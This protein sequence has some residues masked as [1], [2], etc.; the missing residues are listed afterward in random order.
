MY[1]S[2]TQSPNG[3]ASDPT[4]AIRTR[5]NPQALVPL[6]RQILS[7]QDRAAAADAVMTMEQ[8][9]MGSLAR[10]RLYAIVLTGFAGFA[11][12]ISGVGL[13]GVLSYSVTQRSKEL[14][15]RAA[16]GARPADI[17]RLV[18]R[19]G[20]T[21]SVAGIALGLIGSIVFA[22]WMGS[23]LYQVKSSDTT[24]FLIVPLVLLAMAAL[25]CLV[26]A[27]RAAKLDPLKVLRA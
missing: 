27:R 9:V 22:R 4:I 15:V 3:L 21:I 7:T 12:A 5:G 26:P 24:T 2:Y 19:E 25:A 16:L 14:G 23:F 20:L 10:P 13:F 11:L 6:L 8:R 17:V 18:L 1:V